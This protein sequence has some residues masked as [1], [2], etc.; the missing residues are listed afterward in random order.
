MGVEG[1]TTPRFW[2]GGR[3]GNG[4]QILGWGWWEVAGQGVSGVVDVSIDVGFHL[5]LPPRGNPT[6]GDIFVPVPVP[7]LVKGEGPAL[8]VYTISD[9]LPLHLFPP[10]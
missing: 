8:V 9:R 6:T 10:F 4:P 5:L 3:G 2:A 7:S 1:V